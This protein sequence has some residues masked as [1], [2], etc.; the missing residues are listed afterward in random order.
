[1]RSAMPNR[2]N[3]FLS[4]SKPYSDAAIDLTFAINMIVLGGVTHA[5]FVFNEVKVN[6]PQMGYIFFL[7][8]ELV[9]P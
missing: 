7:P 1:M 8:L 6:K 3:Q 9:S 2:H 4:D 5:N